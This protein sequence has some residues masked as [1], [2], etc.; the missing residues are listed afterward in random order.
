LGSVRAPRSP[1]ERPH[2]CRED[3]APTRHKS[4]EG[5][6]LSPDHPAQPRRRTGALTK[7]V[8]FPP[9]TASLNH[10]SHFRIPPAD[11]YAVHPL[12]SRCRRCGP[13][14]RHHGAPCYG[15]HAGPLR[16]PKHDEP[17][18]PIDPEAETRLHFA[19]EEQGRSQDCGT[20]AGEGTQEAGCLRETLSRD[21]SENEEAPW[22]SPWTSA[23]KNPWRIVL[24]RKMSLKQAGGSGHSWLGWLGQVWAEDLDIRTSPRG[25]VQYVPIRSQLYNISTAVYFGISSRQ[26]HLG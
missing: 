11:C 2:N 18:H 19:H 4:G 16:S 5:L 17:E 8:L 10:T 1:R 15:R 7:N 22:T 26:L 6:P 13:D 12:N 25:S 24:T 9:L 21:D 20:E 14:K 3:D 23:R